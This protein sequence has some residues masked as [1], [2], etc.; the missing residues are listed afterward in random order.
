MRKQQDYRPSRLRS[1]AGECEY[2]AKGFRVYLVS[3]REPLKFW[4]TGVTGSKQL[5][6]Y[7]V[8]TS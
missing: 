3:S 6:V 4:S 5:T 1:G 8:E 7:S 2:Q